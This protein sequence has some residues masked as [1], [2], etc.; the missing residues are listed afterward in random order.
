MN[1]PA[2]DLG[3]V[4]AIASS[5]RNIAI[6]PYTVVFGEV[7]LT[8]EVRGVNMA[9]K[10]VIEAAKLG[11]KRC[12]LPKANLKGLKKMD[13]MK[14]YGVSNISEVLEIIIS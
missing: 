5:F 2:L 9:E 3:V 11:F 13:S 1:E 10:R 6:D 14:V 7:G 4:A 8:G 12:I